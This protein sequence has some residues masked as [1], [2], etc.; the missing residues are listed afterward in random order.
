MSSH[1][2]TFQSLLPDYARG[3]AGLG[4]GAGFWLLAPDTPHVAAIFGG[5][6]ALFLLFTI[7]TIIR[8]RTRIEMTDETISSGGLRRVVLRWHD[9]DHVKL[10]YYSTRRNR[11]G[12][13]MTLRLKNGRRAISVD[14]NIGGFEAIA[15]RAAQAII[16]R[17]LPA[18]DVTIANLAALGFMTSAPTAADDRIGT[19][20]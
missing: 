14:S 1:H 6:T 4:V 9:L 7:R 11:S 17:G 12:G 2:Y 19:A 10:R 13:W 18:D 8:Q 3:L 15:A 5:L 20:R 16:D